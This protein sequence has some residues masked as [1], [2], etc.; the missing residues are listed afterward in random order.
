MGGWLVK[1]L[2]GGGWMVSEGW[3]DG[4]MVSGWADGW[5]VSG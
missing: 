3:E 1:G 4:R 2:V 5:M